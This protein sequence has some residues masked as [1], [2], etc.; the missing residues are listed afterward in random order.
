MKKD[1]KFNGIQMDPYQF[2]CMRYSF[3]KKLQEKQ[4]EELLND[5]NPGTIKELHIQYC[6]KCEEKLK[7][8]KIDLKD[9]EIMCDYCNN[10]PICIR[11]QAIVVL[12]ESLVNL[13]FECPEFAIKNE[14]LK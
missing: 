14:L 8:Q 6:P 12:Q 5:E 1:L 3:M 10:Q 2:E 7:M 4:Q 11:S 13:E 9:D